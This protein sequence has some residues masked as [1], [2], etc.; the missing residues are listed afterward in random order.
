M[1]LSKQELKYVRVYIICGILFW[2]SLSS[3]RLCLSLQ[4]W[5]VLEVFIPR[6]SGPEWVPTILCR[7]LP[8]LFWLPLSL[9]GALLVSVA[10]C[11]STGVQWAQGERERGGRLR[12]EEPLGRQ[13]SPQTQGH[14]RHSVARLDQMLVSKRSFSLEEGYSHVCLTA[15]HMDASV[16]S[17]TLKPQLASLSC[18]RKIML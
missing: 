10:T 3:C 1:H 7:R 13:K 9:R 15:D 5:P 8:G 4:G 6:L 16:N 11:W 2:K 17:T 14:R 12:R 18:G